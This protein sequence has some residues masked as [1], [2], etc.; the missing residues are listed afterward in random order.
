MTRAGRLIAGATFEPADLKILAAVFGELW[1]SIA[2]LY[3]NDL[4]T[5]E[6][7]R[8]KLATIVLDLAKD[9]QLSALQITRTA[10]RLI[11]EAY[12]T[13]RVHPPGDAWASK[14]RP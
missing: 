12:A 9:G 3:G 7:T 8:L 5:I 1:A 11:R 6:E 13:Q 2:P 10:G 4:Q 14:M